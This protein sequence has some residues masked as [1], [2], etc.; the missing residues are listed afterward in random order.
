MN[1]FGSLLICVAGW[2]NR[3]QQDVIEY[4]QKKIC[5]LREQ[6]DRR[7]SPSVISHLIASS[8]EVNSVLAWKSGVHRPT[9]LSLADL[10]LR[11]NVPMADLLGTQLGAADFTLQTDGGHQPSRRRFASP[12]KTDLEKMRQVLEAAANDDM[13][14]APSLNKLAIKLKCKQTLIELGSGMNSEC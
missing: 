9:L 4:L 5:V 14:P 7:Q 1:P 2:L 8:K 12:P 11:V 6:L 13:F 3:N 10:S